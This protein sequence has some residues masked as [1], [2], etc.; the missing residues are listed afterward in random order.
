MIPEYWRELLY[1][2]GFLSAIAFGTR[3][4]IQWILTERKGH[5]V[6]PKI[7]WEISIIGNLLLL[8]HSFIQLQFHVGIVQAWNGVIAWRNINLMKE[9]KYQ[10]AFKT[11]I[12]LLLIASALVVLG[13]LINGYFSP[14]GWVWFRAPLLGADVHI[15]IM[16]HIFGFISYICFSSRFWVQWVESEL[17]KKSRLSLTFWWLSLIGGC[18]SILY[19]WHIRDWVNLIG[20]LC[21]LIPYIRNIMLA[22]R[23]TDDKGF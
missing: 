2:L 9:R 11:V 8:I 12:Y 4:L 23:I 22:K 15:G 10:V 17:A 20:P 19:F 6:V 7:F 3:F 16:W 21:G 14:E 5:T 18:F 1:P 13:F